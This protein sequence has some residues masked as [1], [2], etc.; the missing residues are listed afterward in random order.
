MSILI[1]PSFN[2]KKRVYYTADGIGDVCEGDF[3]SDQVPDRIDVCP[4]NAEV[5]QTDF[6]TFQTVTLDPLGDAQID[7]HWIVQNQVKF[8]CLNKTK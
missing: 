7:P 1:Q 6:R 4:E 5:R 3:D 8:V 2:E